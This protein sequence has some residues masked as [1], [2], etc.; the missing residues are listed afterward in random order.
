MN[1]ASQ[2]LERVS[3][4][5]SL[6]R[7]FVKIGRAK[8]L[9]NRR[10]PALVRVENG[11]CYRGRGGRPARAHVQ[12]IKTVLR[13]FG[14]VPLPRFGG[15][16]HPCARTYRGPTT[17]DRSRG[18]TTSRTRQIGRATAG[19]TCVYYT[20]YGKHAGQT[21]RTHTA[22]HSRHLHHGGIRIHNII[23]IMAARVRLP[24]TAI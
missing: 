19:G 11:N 16:R 4:R 5:Q 18:S 3:Q 23:I 13:V 10:F 14:A 2:H 22:R 12:R 20:R 6:R 1:R 7:P 17:S 9:E 21:A 24:N 15:E 8:P